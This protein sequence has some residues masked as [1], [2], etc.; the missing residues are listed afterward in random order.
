M[1]HSESIAMSYRSSGSGKSAGAEGMIAA[2][3]PAFAESAS[4]RLHRWFYGLIYAVMPARISLVPRLT[5]LTI[6]HMFAPV[7]MRERLPEGP[8]YYTPRGLVGV[9]NDLRVDTI[10]ANYR[11]GFFPVSH[12]GAMKWWSPSE[13]AVLS[14]EGTHVSKNL[15]RMIRQKKFTVTFDQDFAGVIRGCAAPREGK[16]ELTW[17]TP[18]IMN[19]YW[20]LHQG[21]YAHSVEVRDQDGRLVGGLYGVAI[22]NVFFGESQFS[23]ADH[24]SKIAVAYLHAHLAQWGFALRDGK[25]MTPHLA[26]LGFHAVARSDYLAQLDRHAAVDRKPDRWRVDETFDI[27]SWYADPK[28]PVPH[29]A[30]A[31]RTAPEESPIPRTV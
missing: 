19:A 6:A 17:I 26:T 13:R 10:L 15:L 24:T 31:R 5:L 28:R 11:R 30:A 25:W 27:A 14:P 8:I 9:S 3:R 20:D 1:T 21:G 12:L 2:S 4:A 29:G 23:H 7:E 18:R 16:P 22:G